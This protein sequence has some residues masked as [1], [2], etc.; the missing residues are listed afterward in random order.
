MLKWEHNVTEEQAQG[1]K[2]TF[3]WPTDGSSHLLPDGIVDRRS[4]AEP[5]H[6]SR[7]CDHLLLQTISKASGWGTIAAFVIG[8]LITGLVQ[9]AVIQWSIKGAG[10]MDILLSMIS[11]C[12]LYRVCL[13]FV[14]LAIAIWF[15]LRIAGKKG[16]ELPETG[17]V[18]LCFHALGYSSYFTTLVR[19]SAD[20]SVDMFN[21]DNPVSLMGLYQP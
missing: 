9:K 20:P 5:A 7:D 13:F 1:V 14:L 12:L 16:M 15:G 2:G 4:P 10:N 17:P 8:C 19:S 21:V 11:A 3:T 18:E 6:H